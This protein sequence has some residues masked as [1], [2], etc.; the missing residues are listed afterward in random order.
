MAWPRSRCRK[1]LAPLRYMMAQHLGP[2]VFNYLGVE[3]SLRVSEDAMNE[4]AQHLKAGL[5]NL[6]SSR[7]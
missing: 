6:D 1:M 5:T 7:Y 4:L 2:K 3:D